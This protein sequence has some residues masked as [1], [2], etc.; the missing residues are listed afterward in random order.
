[1]GIA[2]G[3]TYAQQIVMHEREVIRV[4]SNLSTQEAAA[5]PEAFLTAYDALEQLELR[6]GQRLLIHG[7]GSGVGL[8][9]L[10]LAR[11]MG[12]EVVGTSRTKQKLDQIEGLTEAI[13]VEDGN[14]QRS[15][16]SKVDAIIDFIG[17]AYLDQNLRSLKVGGSMI[18]LGLLGGGK[19]SIN[20]GLL[21]VKKLRILGSTLRSRPLESKIELAQRFSQRILPLFETSRVRPHLDRVYGWTKVQEAHAY[22]ESNQNTGKLV[23]RISHS[24]SELEPVR[25]E[26]TSD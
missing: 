19:A 16:D 2:S 21:L 17:G 18:V 22:M 1:M 9:A 4:P 25:K 20:L 13:W 14:F 5:I 11:Q 3:E 24:A 12:I 26:R 15:L 6:L 23:L 8:A 10:Q 7:I